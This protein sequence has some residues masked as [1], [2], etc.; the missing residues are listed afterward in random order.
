MKKLFSLLLLAA[1]F[2]SACRIGASRRG[3]GNI[4]SEQRQTESFTG[5][6]VSDIISAEV[7]QGD[8]TAVEVS[9]DDNIIEDVRT[10]VKNG[11]LYIRFREGINNFNN[12]HIKVYVTAPVI[13]SLGS[14]GVGNITAKGLLKDGEKISVKTSGTGSITADVDAPSVDAKVTG[15]GGIR[16]GGRTQNYH[17]EV[18][19]SGSIKG[20]DLL[21]ENAEA[22]VSGVGSIQLHA[23]VSLKARVSG[24]GSVIYRGA[25]NV[26][27]QVSGVGSV[28]KEG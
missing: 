9:A 4:I 20:F 2:F 1:T 7:Q 14:T 27:S 21:T 17:A 12:V 18:S 10:T 3:S 16:L 22:K 25:A 28:K 19:G 15:V 23:S 8:A 13:Q 11:V 26:E 6:V 5:V 24:V